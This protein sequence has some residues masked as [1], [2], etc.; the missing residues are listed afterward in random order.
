MRADG[1]S[2]GDAPAGM[3]L[4][5]KLLGVQVAHGFSSQAHVFAELLAD[6]NRATTRAF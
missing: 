6:A 4:V 3:D 1:E 5:T 2:H